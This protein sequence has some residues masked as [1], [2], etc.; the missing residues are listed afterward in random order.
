MRS[1]FYPKLAITNIKKNSRFYY[2]YLLT[3]IATV[4]MFYVMVMI[5]NNDGLYKMPSY[6]ALVSILGFGTVI[7]GIFSTIFLLY[8]NSFLIKRRKKELG[9]FNILGMEKRHISR[10]LFNESII[11]SIFT[12]TLGLISG[13]VLSKLM[14]LI[15][16]KLI[17]FSVPIKFELKPYPIILT[18]LLFGSISLFTLIINVIQVY[19]SKPIELVLGNNA[20]EKEPKSRL[21]I[22]IIGL[23]SLVS[24]YII[25]ITTESPLTAINLFFVAVLLVI[26]GTYCLFISGSITLL[27][28]L[29]RNKIFFY[30]KKNFIAVSSMFYRMKQNAVGLASIC[31]LSTMVLV[32]VSTTVSLYIGVQDALDMRYPSDIVIQL[33]NP[34]LGEGNKLKE[35]VVNYLNEN[36]IEVDQMVSYTDFPMIL[37]N[38]G[39][40][41]S[42]REEGQSYED[43]N[44]SVAIMKY[45][46][47]FDITKYV[48]ELASNEVLVY[49][50]VNDINNSIILFDKE[51]DVKKHARCNAS[52]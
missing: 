22:T 4:A 52:R 7:V 48:V 47:Y 44:S 32:M 10:I 43:M 6:G 25:A 11:S 1:F 8:T 26:I 41:F 13:I 40:K 23:I 12:I 27:K 36:D 20:G 21:W 50:N 35:L 29:R 30:N 17:Q 28:F 16:F 51:Y 49:S 3:Y 45:Q 38:N 39:N 2:P 18:I 37:V 34:L 33:H 15:L 5:A 19:M 31:I 9:L 42:F 24:G 14:F 46:D